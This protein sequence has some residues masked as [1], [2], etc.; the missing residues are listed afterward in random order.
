MVASRHFADDLSDIEKHIWGNE[1]KGRAR[2]W[3]HIR[4]VQKRGRPFSMN[5]PQ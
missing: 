4:L 1:C 5:E 2:A 3:M